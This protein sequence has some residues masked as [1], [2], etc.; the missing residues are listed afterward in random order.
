MGLGPR[1]VLPGGWY[2]DFFVPPIR[3][4][5]PPPGWAALVLLSWYGCVPCWGAHHPLR[6]AEL[7]WGVELG[8]EVVFA[9]LLHIYML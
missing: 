4:L 1:Q 3:P 8:W 9:S 7:G 2:W 5:I 6:A